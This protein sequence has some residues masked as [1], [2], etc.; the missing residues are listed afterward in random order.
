MWSLSH[1]LKVHAAHLGGPAAGL[2]VHST[3]RPWS[4]SLLEMPFL[5]QHTGEAGPN[6]SCGLWSRLDLDL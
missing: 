3:Q 4:W 5:K 2:Q 1:A 6:P